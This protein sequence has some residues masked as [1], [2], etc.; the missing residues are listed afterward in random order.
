MTNPPVIP[1]ATKRRYRPSGKSLERKTQ[2]RP[3]SWCSDDFVNVTVF[4]QSDR[5]ALKAGDVNQD[6][7][8]QP[9]RSLYLSYNCTWTIVA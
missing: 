2:D 5:M 7:L 4:G 1:A 8:V 9:Q 6:V 3:K